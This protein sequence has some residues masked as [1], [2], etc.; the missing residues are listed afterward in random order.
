MGQ[1]AI[2]VHG[3]G[4]HHNNDPEFRGDANVLAKE[5]VELLQQ[6]GHRITHASFATD[7]GVNDNLLAP[8]S[9]QGA[10]PADPVTTRGE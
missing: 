10:A 7:G 5:F 6:H 1:Y 8:T 3:V 4:S 9:D 2:V